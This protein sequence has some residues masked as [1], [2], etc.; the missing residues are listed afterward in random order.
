[1]GKKSKQMKPRKQRNWLA[2]A[3]W[4]RGGAGAHEDASAYKRK[5]LS[6]REIEELMDEDTE[7][8]DTQ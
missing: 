8:E 1:M 7:R 6:P 3:A 2:V 5:K 4:E